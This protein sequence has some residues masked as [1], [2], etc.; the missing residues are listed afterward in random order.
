MAKFILVR[1]KFKKPLEK[2][3]PI[4]A[5]LLNIF[6]Y[7]WLVNYSQI[8]LSLLCLLFDYIHSLD[9][10]KLANKIS[11]RTKKIEKKIKRYLSKSILDNETQKSGIDQADLVWFS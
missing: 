8:K 4:Q 3:Q 11:W 9:S 10:L 1:I 2:W 5:G 7:I 6:N